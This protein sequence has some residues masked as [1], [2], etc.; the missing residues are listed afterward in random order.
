[1]AAA[2]RHLRARWI[3]AALGWLLWAVTLTL[4]I[5]GIPSDGMWVIYPGAVRE[6]LGINF[7]I[8]SAQHVIEVA[9]I[10]G[11]VIA[12][13]VLAISP[14]LMR[15]HRSHNPAVRRWRW[16]GLGLFAMVE[17]SVMFIAL[18]VTAQLPLFIWPI[19]LFVLAHVVVGVAILPWPGERS[20]TP[21]GFEVLIP[22][23]QQSD[24]QANEDE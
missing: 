17:L 9:A 13:G 18:Q 16:L 21:S 24:C 6:A 5:G 10:V 23:A 11:F 2:P 7:R 4:P 20:L 8:E 15:L 19:H 3:I 1:M 12:S 22:D 14:V